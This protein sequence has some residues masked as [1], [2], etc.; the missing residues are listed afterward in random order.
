MIKTKPNWKTVKGVEAWLK[1]LKLLLAEAD[2]AAGQDEFEPRHEV[3]KFLAGFIQESW[4]QTPEM[5]KL[6][7]LARETVNSLMLADIQQR[8]GAIASRTADYAKLAKDFDAVAERNAAAADSIRLKGVQELIEATTQTVVSAKALASSL[9]DSKTDEKKLAT[10]IED[11]VG[12][13]EKLRTGVAQL[14]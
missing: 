3:S 1:E 6:D 8:L 11:T 12:A 10:L 7:E 14:I 2:K 4:P 5:D 13:V 9:D